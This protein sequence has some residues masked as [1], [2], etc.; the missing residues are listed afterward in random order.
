MKKRKWIWLL[1]VALLPGCHRFL[2]LEPAGP[3]TLIAL[4]A[5]L[6][7][8]D[9]EHTVWA[10]YA[11]HDAVSPAEDLTV[12]CYVNGGEAARVS[13]PAEVHGGSAA[14]RLRMSL[15]PGDR[16]RLT[17]S[18]A[19]GKAEA[20]TV[21]PPAPL[22]EHVEVEPFTEVAADGREIPSFRFRIRLRDQAGERNWFRLQLFKE[23]LTYD[24]MRDISPSPAWQERCTIE[25]V[26]GPV[27]PDTEKEPLLNPAA[28]APTHDWDRNYFLNRYN[29]FS[30]ELFQDGSYTLTVTAPAADFLVPTPRSYGSSG[31]YWDAEAG[32]WV[33][34][35]M[36]Y[37]CQRAARVRVHSLFREDYLRSRLQDQNHFDL[38]GI[39]M[40]DGLFSDGMVY[41][42]NVSGGTGL[43][44]A[45]SATDIRIDLGT[46]AYTIEDIMHRT[47]Y[48]EP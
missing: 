10:S 7:T 31:E 12:V 41:P 5:R 16:I 29:L 48:P 44:S 13:S 28:A 38:T 6:S 14:Y 37:V 27:D 32:R 17:A 9:A 3:D 45:R 21:V 30:D 42:E 25:N 33:R 43:V 15:A 22:L 26:F 47:L 46:A 18:S 40:F 24:S 34:Y 2:D 23:R 8:V 36:R 1:A 20:E 19:I 11:G 35:E 39:W 4:E